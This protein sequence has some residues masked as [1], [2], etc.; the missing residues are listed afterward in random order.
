MK[1]MPAPQSKV[2][3]RKLESSP[4]PTSKNAKSSKLITQ[5]SSLKASKV[6][7]LQEAAESPE[8]ELLKEKYEALIIEND[9]NIEKIHFLEDKIKDLEV[10]KPKK[11]NSKTKTS[12]TSMSDKAMYPCKICIYTTTCEDEIKWHL[13]EEHGYTGLYADD[14]IPC[15]HCDKLIQNMN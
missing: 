13:E 12:Q 1:T 6:S 14:S 8:F 9:R 5:V 3:K 15:K 10:N 7:K 4:I 11:K 2:G